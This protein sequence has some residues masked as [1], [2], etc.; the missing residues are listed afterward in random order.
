M[1]TLHVDETVDDVSW[2][3][4]EAGWLETLVVDGRSPGGWHGLPVFPVL[5]DLT[6]NSWRGRIDFARFPALERLLIRLA[7][8]GIESLFGVTAPIKMLSLGRSPTSDLQPLTR[9][10]LER[11]SLSKA[12][13]LQSLEGIAAHSGTLRHLELSGN[14]SLRS[15]DD[16]VHLTALASVSIHRCPHL[17]NLDALA[18]IP[19]LKTVALDD[20]PN[21]LS[22]ETLRR[23]PTLRLTLNNMDYLR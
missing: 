10:E 15:I 8:T 21:I 3:A 9:F 12:P 14:E 2:I 17:T 16:V 1:T 6:I 11:L 22:I 13:R 4:Q 19:S 5:T 23:H 7:T 20:N 18:E